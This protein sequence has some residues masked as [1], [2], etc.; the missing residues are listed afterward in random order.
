MLSHIGKCENCIRPARA[1]PDDRDHADDANAPSASSLMRGQL[2]NLSQ[3]TV[4]V[5]ITERGRLEMEGG[6]IDDVSLL[7]NRT[8]A[9]E[10]RIDEMSL[11]VN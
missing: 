4:A 9:M 7:D 11:L 5:M 8:S 6:G 10:P 2:E 1:E 3:N